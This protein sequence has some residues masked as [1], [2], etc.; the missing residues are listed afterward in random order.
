MTIKICKVTEDDEVSVSRICLLTADAGVS[1]E[2]LH[3]FGELPGLVY[4]VPYIRMPTTWGFVL[5][6]EAA[7][8][9]VGYV[10]GS[11]IHVPMNS[12]QRSM[13]GLLLWRSIASK[14]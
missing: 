14:K 13:G 3:D 11:T 12:T 2:A 9:V 7:Q 8:E 4:A 1:A 10:L 6:D 5:E